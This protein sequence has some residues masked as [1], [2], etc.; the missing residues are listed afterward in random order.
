MD[1]VSSS[2]SYYRR[3]MRGEKL[4]FKIIVLVNGYLISITPL[5]A[6]EMQCRA[7]TVL[8]WLLRALQSRTEERPLNVRPRLR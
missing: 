5:S 1:V 4:V 3:G 6:S 2:R 7:G 8:A